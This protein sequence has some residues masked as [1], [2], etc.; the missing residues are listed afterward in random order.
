MSFTSASI[1]R[2]RVG[3]AA[4][5]LAALFC[6][7]MLVAT[8]SA[9]PQ[10]YNNVD[11]TFRGGDGKALAKCYNGARAEAKYIKRTGHARANQENGCENTAEA[12]GGEVV[13][14]DFDVEIKQKG[15]QKTNSNSVDIT[16][17]AGDAT[18]VAACVNVA[19]GTYDR[20]QVNDCI[21]SAVAFGG[22]VILKNVE[23]D[24]EQS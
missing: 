6:L 16:M 1:T 24:I 13:M 3:L 22:S 11:L 7:V 21:N 2:A 23:L 5:A 4:L 20:E 18:A 9:S 12:F 19:Q 8:A 17:R 10:R 14:E 15:G